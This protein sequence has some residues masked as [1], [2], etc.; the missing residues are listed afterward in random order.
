MEK[1]IGRREQ[2]KQQTRQA[3]IKAA[4]EEFSV[5]GV[6]DTAVAHIMK[7]AG[8]GLGTFYNYFSSKNEVLLELTAAPVR[9]VKKQFAE[10]KKKNAAATE[11]LA[12]LSTTVAE[13]IDGHH[14]ILQLFNSAADNFSRAVG[15]CPPKSPGFKVLFEQIIRDGQRDGEIRRDI[16]TEVMSEMFHAIYQAAAL[17]KLDMPYKENVAQKINLLLCGMKASNV[18]L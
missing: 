17:S 18:S 1:N 11:I 14:F 12:A 5:R 13:F 7:R 2:K 16:P 3:I 8:L 6:A 10:L 15:D 4:V 9:A